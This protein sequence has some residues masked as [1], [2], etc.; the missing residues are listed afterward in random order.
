MLPQ[1]ERPTDPHRY[2][3][4]YA[5]AARKRRRWP[6]IVGGVAV[7]C[8]GLIAV[9][10]LVVASGVL[11]QVTAKE[12]PLTADERGLLLDAAYIADWMDG[13]EPDPGK[14]VATKRVY[15]DDS[16]EIEYK[17]EHEWE[18]GA[19]FLYHS[20][21]WEPKLTDAIAIYTS[22]WVGAK[23]G[24]K[25]GGGTAATIE[26]QQGFFEWGEVSR[27]G[28]LKAE[29]ALFGN[30]FIARSGKHVTYFMVSGVYFDEPESFSE[31]LTPYLEKMEQLKSE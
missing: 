2:Q 24:L 28:F 7:G 4:S 13:F 8:V 31:L 21:F 6:W 18:D 27:F 9:V 20:V 10:A 17:Y 1:N 25:F 29:E 12:V 26:E 22:L 23:V 11:Y 15:F 16:Y 5:A 3:P 14:E 30:V 19:L